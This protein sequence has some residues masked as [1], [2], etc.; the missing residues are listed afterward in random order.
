VNY[1]LRGVDVEPRT[2]EWRERPSP[3]LQSAR[4]GSS[5]PTAGKV[6]ARR[7]R[8]GPI[9]FL[10]ARYPVIRRL[11]GELSFRVVARRYTLSHLPSGVVPNSF[12]DS[13]PHF[14]RSLGNAACIE[15]VADV[16]ELEMLR[17][18]TQYAPH[19]RP[20]VALALS[21]LQVER[22]NGLRVLVHPSVC[23]VQSRFP[24]VTT[25][26][27][28][29]TS[30]GDGMIERWPLKPPSWPGRSLKWKSDAFRPAAMPSFAHY[31]KEKPWQQPSRSQPKS[32]PNSTW[33]QASG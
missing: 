12:G 19:V 6:S 1:S 26:E 21:S 17:H 18:K 10:A 13:F 23:L 27:N 2:S 5:R 28:N 15:Y 25:W 32:P 7:D 22:L 30:D 33:F 20:L 11:V 16:A 8:L 9:E 24:I 14:I 31:P 4:V 3:R 29:Q